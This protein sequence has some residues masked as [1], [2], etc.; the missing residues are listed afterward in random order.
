MAG[1]GFGGCA[2]NHWVS[3]HILASIRLSTVAVPGGHRFNTVAVPDSVL[4]RTKVFGSKA[5]SF[6]LRSRGCHLRVA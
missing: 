6:S 1:I 2:S 4:L 5:L 3:E